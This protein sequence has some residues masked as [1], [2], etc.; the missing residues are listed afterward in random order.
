MILNTPGLLGPGFGKQSSRHPVVSSGILPPG[1]PLY[2]WDGSDITTMYSDD[3]ATILI[4]GTDEDVVRAHVS[5]GSDAAVLATGA[6]D[7]HVVFDSGWTNSLGALNIDHAN[8]TGLVGAHA[9]DYA[10]T[11][12]VVL[13]ILSTSNAESATDPFAFTDDSNPRLQI[14]FDD[15][16]SYVGGFQM[17]HLGDEVHVDP[18]NDLPFGVIMA[19]TDEG[20]APISRA[21]NSAGMYQ[22]GAGHT[23][24][25]SAE[26]MGW[27]W[28]TSNVNQIRGGEIIAWQ[29]DFAEL[30][31]T[32][33][34]I[35]AY[36][37]EKW[38]FTFEA[39]AP[40]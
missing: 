36:V 30:G 9:T 34:D 15:P 29:G 38:G 40:V 25:E 31:F 13:M 28:W 2:W 12:Y 32:D 10:A 7:T 11:G 21:S 3:E 6:A 18:G 37:T 1:S 8:A 5:K 4:S 14:L 24:W 22:A 39:A 35:I 33:E 26:A 27:A 16:T 23:D 19:S 17:R 20:A